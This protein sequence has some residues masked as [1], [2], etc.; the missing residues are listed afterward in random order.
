MHVSP[1]TQ[2]LADPLVVEDQRRPA[3]GAIRR[4]TARLWS[5]LAGPNR[6]A[7]HGAEP[8]VAKA[9]GA[10]LEEAGTVWTA[11][12]GIAQTQ[13]RDATEQLLQGFA[14]ILEQLDAIIDPDGRGNGV[15]ASGLDGRAAVLEQCESQLRSLIEGFQGFVQSRDQVM[16]SVRSLA[17]ASTT[18]HAMAE[19]VAKIARQTNLLSI[20]AAIEA[21]RAGDSGR[22]FSVVAVEVRRLSTESGET[23][24]RIADQVTDFGT[25]MNDALAQA[26]DHNERD[27]GAIRESEDTIGRVVE[28]VDAAVSQLN[29]RAA[30][31]SARG[32]AV[33]SQVEQLMVAFQFQDRVNQIMDQVSSSIASGIARLQQSL[34][35]GR[36]PEPDEWA[37]LLSAGYTTAE[38][39]AVGSGASPSAT[40]SAPAE[41]TFF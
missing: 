37:A 41:T 18:L 13:M 19:D 25:R 24:K 31:L 12:L 27:A 5:S 11:H 17:G 9:V 36:V 33:R 2:D 29:A 20:N 7:G 3:P 4:T 40:A 30:D 21:A 39:R 8:S 16:Q 35:A 28:Q 1:L 23:G 6:Q 10:R 34:A 26:V 15:S 14:R 38:Q 22:A 32:E